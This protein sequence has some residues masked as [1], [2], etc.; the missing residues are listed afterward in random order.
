MWSAGICLY[1]M[2]VGTVPFRGNSMGELH[3]KIMAGKYD[4]NS[5]VI[6][7]EAK[8]LLARLLCTNFKKRLS[9]KEALEHEWL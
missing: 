4:V 1:V 8:N 5:E 7:P 9:A 6:S 2:L 3:R